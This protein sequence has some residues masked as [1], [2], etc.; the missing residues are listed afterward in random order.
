MD[1]TKIFNKMAISRALRMLGYTTKTNSMVAYYQVFTTRNLIPQ[2]QFWNETKPAG[3][4][5]TL[6]QWII[7]A[8]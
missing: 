6:R 1:N 4:H 2:Q 7:N 8:D 3:V 5:E